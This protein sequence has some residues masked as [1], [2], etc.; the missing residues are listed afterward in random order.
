MFFIFFLKYY[1][2]SIVAITFVKCVLV[3]GGGKEGERMCERE[4]ECV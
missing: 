3:W 1:I 2:M 4:R